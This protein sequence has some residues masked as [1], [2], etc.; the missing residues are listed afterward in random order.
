[1]KI[2]RYLIIKLEMITRSTTNFNNLKFQLCS[3]RFYGFVLKRDNHIGQ[4]IPNLSTSSNEKVNSIAMG[5]D[6]IIIS[7]SSENTIFQPPRVS[8]K[9][10][11]SSSIFNT[12][13][14]S[15]SIRKQ[16]KDKLKNRFNFQKIICIQA[17]TAFTINWT[18]ELAKKALKSR[19]RRS[20]MLIYLDEDFFPLI[21]MSDLQTAIQS[22]KYGLQ[23]FQFT[24]LPEFFLWLEEQYK[25]RQKEIKKLI[26]KNLFRILVNVNVTLKHKSFIDELKNYI[27]S[28]GSFWNSSYVMIYI[29]PTPAGSLPS[30]PGPNSP[31]LAASLQH[32][33]FRDEENFIWTTS[34]YQ[35]ILDFI[36][37]RKSFL[38]KSN[39]SSHSSPIISGSG[40]HDSLDELESHNSAPL[41]DSQASSPGGPSTPNKEESSPIFSAFARKLSKSAQKRRG[42]PVIG[43]RKSD[44]PTVTPDRPFE[45]INSHQPLGPFL[46]FEVTISG[47]DQQSNISVG[48]IPFGYPACTFPGTAPGSFAWHSSDG[49]LHCGNPNKKYTFH[50]GTAVSYGNDVIGC[51]YDQDSHQLFWTKNGKL[52]GYATN[53]NSI[54]NDPLTLLYPAVGIQ[55]PGIEISANFGS[56]Y[57]FYFDRTTNIVHATD[58]DHQHDL[59]T[60][61]FL[62]LNPFGDDLFSEAEK[63]QENELLHLIQISKYSF[64]L[65]CLLRAHFAT[66]SEKSLI[67]NRKINY[68]EV[69]FSF[70]KNL[71]VST[72]QYMVQL[73]KKIEK[74]N[75]VECS[76]VTEHLFNLGHQNH[77]QLQTYQHNF[78]NTSSL[79]SLV[80]LNLS[81]IEGL[82][83]LTAENIVAICTNLQALHV[84]RDINDSCFQCLASLSSLK[85]LEIVDCEYLTDAGTQA[86]FSNRKISLINLHFEKCKLLT[87][88]TLKYLKNS[89]SSSSL[90][91]LHLSI[92]KGFSENQI[93]EIIPAKLPNLISIS[94]AGNADFK[95]PVNDAILENICGTYGSK[96][97]ALNLYRCKSLSQNSIKK[98]AEQCKEIRELNI[99]HLDQLDDGTLN[100]IAVECSKLERL[101]L[102]A[103][104]LTRTTL[105][106]FSLT[107]KNLVELSIQRC[108]NITIVGIKEALRSLNNLEFLSLKENTIDDSVLDLLGKPAILPK[109]KYL[110][111]RRCHKYSPFAFACLQ[112]EKPNWI[113]YSNMDPSARFTFGKDIKSLNYSSSKLQ[114]IRHRKNSL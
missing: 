102:V 94:F 39:I 105:F 89:P 62:Q 34:S 50:N 10:I 103:T 69:N 74:L 83:E 75:L 17:D 5:S 48:V 96:I 42:T 51:G 113:I 78:W 27:R 11:Q 33:D 13:R 67:Q 73:F 19:F 41:T 2:G 59:R 38:E 3:L 15:F 64:S 99:G 20:P 18:P 43:L 9:M 68:N 66:R 61:S 111:I 93:Q 31:S 28:P 35:S 24:N 65:Q 44:D 22:S 14:E 6:N 104:Q 30:S 37:M 47:W 100:L 26:Q 53:N 1:M 12:D 81:S 56:E 25:K 21:R 16:I 49:L 92:C 29:S 97:H 98:I 45:F 71:K 95:P 46:Y 86:F 88:A 32:S 87:D 4:L 40:N 90:Q 36:C 114:S 55:Q 72:F 23:V 84:W 52:I 8:W 101:E 58:S 70:C 79:N 91:K 109:L 112:N 80:S 106:T 108:I 63:H 82:T 77:Q 76:N 57:S 60:S 110:D 85:T 54:I 107:A 7:S